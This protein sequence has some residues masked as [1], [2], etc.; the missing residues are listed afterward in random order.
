M[1]S[2]AETTKIYLAIVGISFL[3]GLQFC[4]SPVLGEISAHYPDIDVSFV[5][6]LITAPSLISMVVALISGW[7][8]V[9]ISKKRLLIFAAL[10]AGV[11][12]FIPFLSDSF[13][14]L[15]L[16][17][18]IF[19]ISLGLATALNTAVVAEFFEGPERVTAMGIQAASVGAGMMIITTVGG[20]LGANGFSR[21]YFINIIAFIC[22]AVLALC[23]PETGKVKLKG[24]EKITLTKHVFQTAGFGFLCF[25]FLITFTTNIAMHLS[26]ALEGSSSVAG[27]L[28]GVFSVTQIIIGLVLGVVTGIFKKFTLPA[29]M[30]SFC[31]GAIFFIMFPGNFLMLSIGAAFCGL[32]QGVFVPTAMVEVSNAV[33]A[34]SV[35]MASATFTCAMCLGQFVSPII[36]NNMSKLLFSEVTTTNVYIIAAIGMAISGALAVLWKAREKKNV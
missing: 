18:T 9:K 14:L 15:F 19:G 7:L 3:Q 24:K 34:S 29:A 5:Q 8:V 28:T 6:M 1:R 20:L 2:K 21:S 11:L 33:Q 22:M 32:S 12:G 30:F 10:V 4:V 26:G 13:W 27:T 16:C 25:L 23:L 35:A 31:I 36:L 17:R